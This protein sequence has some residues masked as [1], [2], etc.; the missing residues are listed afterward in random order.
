MFL[1]WKPRCEQIFKFIKRY[2]IDAEANGNVDASSTA[3]TV[4]DKGTL[5]I[6]L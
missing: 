5:W 2:I 4:K 6:S 3:G 1:V